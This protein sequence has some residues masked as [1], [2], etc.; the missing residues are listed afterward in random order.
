MVV[1]GVV[2]IGALV[3]SAE[4]D[5]VDTVEVISDAVQA[6]NTSISTIKQPEITQNTFHLILTVSPKR[7]QSVGLLLKE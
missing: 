1:P 5:V 3:E 7:V 6:D 4:L 2:E